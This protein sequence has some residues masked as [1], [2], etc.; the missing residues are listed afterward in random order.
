MSSSH[1]SKFSVAQNN[2]ANLGFFPLFR[3][4]K[5]SEYNWL[6]WWKNLGFWGYNNNNSLTDFISF[7]I[8]LQFPREQSSFSSIVRNVFISFRPSFHFW[9]SWPILELYN[10]EYVVDGL[11]RWEAL[12]GNTIVKENCGLNIAQS[13]GDERICSNETLPREVV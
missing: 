1:N 6:F 3:S 9:I 7:I 4:Y 8:K 10:T 12:L 11:H 2:T 13:V 5:I